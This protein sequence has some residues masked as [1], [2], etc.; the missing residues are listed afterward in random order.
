MS[1]ESGFGSVLFLR[2]KSWFFFLGEQI[3]GGERV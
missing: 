1:S 3:E 2:Q